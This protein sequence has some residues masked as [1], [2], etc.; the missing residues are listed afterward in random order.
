MQVVQNLR[1]RSYKSA[2]LTQYKSTITSTKVQ[3]LT[4]WTNSRATQPQSARPPHICAA[5]YSA[6]ARRPTRPPQVL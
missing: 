6:A 1:C 4:Q 5:R 3:L 2:I